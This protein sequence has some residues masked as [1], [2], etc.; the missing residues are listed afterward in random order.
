MKKRQNKPS[1]A[2]LMRSRVFTRNL[3]SNLCETV[4]LQNKN[5]HKSEEF[6]NLGGSM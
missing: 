6:T 3:S 5:K 1:S 4:G 2:G